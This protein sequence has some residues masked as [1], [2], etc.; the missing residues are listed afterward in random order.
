MRSRKQPN[1]KPNDSILTIQLFQNIRKENTF[2][3]T[4]K[5]DIN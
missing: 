2:E 4:C 1:G 5:V 3:Q